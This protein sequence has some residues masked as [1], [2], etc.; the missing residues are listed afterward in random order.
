MGLSQ[1]DEVVRGYVQDNGV[2]IAKEHL[3]RIWERFYQVDSAR[4][5]REETSSGL[6]L[7]MVKWIV[8]AHG[9]TIT[10]ES[11]YGTGTKF[12]FEIPLLS[13]E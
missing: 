3:P 1:R 10:A 12:V 5:A 13:K 4:S 11:E 8:E 2:G 7:P 6:G 9:G